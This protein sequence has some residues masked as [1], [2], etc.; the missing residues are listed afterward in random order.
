MT[1]GDAVDTIWSQI[2]APDTTWKSGKDEE[3]AEQAWEAAKVA[4]KQ[5]SICHSTST[6]SP[7]KVTA[8]QPTG[9]GPSSGASGKVRTIG[10]PGVITRG[11][12]PV[13]APPTQE[14]TSYYA[15]DLAW[16]SLVR[17]K[18]NHASTDLLE[19]IVGNLAGNRLWCTVTFKGL[20]YMQSV[21]RHLPDQIPIERIIARII[22]RA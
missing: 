18:E 10:N 14:E 11:G 7:V 16:Q 12:A 21:I 4:A 8:F 2:R 20:L 22:T 3:C 19:G 13:E 17:L 9:F 1:A 6:R 5:H 15:K